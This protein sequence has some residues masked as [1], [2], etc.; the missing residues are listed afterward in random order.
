MKYSTV[1]ILISGGKVGQATN[2]TTCTSITMVSLI[3]LCAAFHTRLISQ[4]RDHDE[5]FP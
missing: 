2:L 5:A 1:Y 4:S 3:I